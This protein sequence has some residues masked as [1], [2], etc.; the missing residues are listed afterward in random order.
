MTVGASSPE[1]L[2]KNYYACALLPS[3]IRRP[4]IPKTKGLTERGNR[5][6]TNIL[7]MYVASDHKNW[8]GFY[9]LGNTLSTLLGT[10]R[11]AAAPSFFCMHGRLVLL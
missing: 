8:V 10:R 5:T 2:R 7:P 9:R 6:L 11:L 4:T 1:M 3:D